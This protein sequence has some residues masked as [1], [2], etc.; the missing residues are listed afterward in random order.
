MCFLL[1]LLA[2][3]LG[4]IVGGA[5][6]SI[7]LAM[8]F[9]ACWGSFEGS[10]AMGGFTVGLPLGALIGVGLGLWPR[11]AGGAARAAVDRGRRHPRRSGNPSG[12]LRLTPLRF[13]SPQPPPTA[14]PRLARA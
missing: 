11:R 7:G 8:F 9:T 12:R 14:P 5:V 3:V 6:F 10:A 2:G 13:S 1:A 4:A